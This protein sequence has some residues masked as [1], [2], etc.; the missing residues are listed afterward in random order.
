MQSTTYF[1]LFYLDERCKYNNLCSKQR[2]SN[3]Q[4]SNDDKKTAN[5][6]YCNLVELNYTVSWVQIVRNVA[7]VVKC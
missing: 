4:R 6:V 5:D 2:Q 1:P 3:N 7:N